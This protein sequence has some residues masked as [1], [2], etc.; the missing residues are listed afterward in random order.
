[1]VNTEF[2]HK[3]IFISS[4]VY[5]VLSKV[6]ATTEGV[7]QCKVDAD[8]AV[9]TKLMKCVDKVCQCQMGYHLTNSLCGRILSNLYC[10]Y[11]FPLI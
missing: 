5:C 4:I 2:T 7:I 1:V 8:C 3:I 11:K 10:Y 6:K 9:F